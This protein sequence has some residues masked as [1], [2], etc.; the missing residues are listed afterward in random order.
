VACAR[1]LTDRSGQ[2]NHITRRLEVQLLLQQVRVYRRVLYGSRGITGGLERLHE[3]NCYAGIQRI[4]RRAGLPP[5]E[6]FRPVV[7]AF[8]RF[9]QSL[10]RLAVQPCKTITLLIEPM[11]EIGRVT[12]KETV[13]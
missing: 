10:K 2:L 7:R 8:G 1:S 11:F 9:G 13:E 3:P 12:K 4:L 6:G 5:F